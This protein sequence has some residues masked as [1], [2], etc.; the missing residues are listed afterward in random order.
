MPEGICQKCKN[1][2]PGQQASKKVDWQCQMLNRTCPENQIC[3]ISRGFFSNRARLH[4]CELNCFYSRGHT[5]TRNIPAERKPLHVTNVDNFFSTIAPTTRLL[6]AYYIQPQNFVLALLMRCIHLCKTAT[7]HQ[8]KV[9]E[10]CSRPVIK[11]V[12][13]QCPANSF[14]LE[15]KQALFFLPQKHVRPLELPSSTH[16]LHS[17]NS[18]YLGPCARFSAPI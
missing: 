16:S 13:R 3:I 4:A 7:G 18:L 12:G 17:T 2:H 9:Q 1:G 6:N 14:W 5:Q 11:G 15:K 8:P 10:W